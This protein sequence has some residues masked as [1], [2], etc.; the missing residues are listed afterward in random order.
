M[1]YISPSLVA[2]ADSGAADPLSHA[3]IGY[4]TITR[5][6]T[7]TASSAAPGFPASSI[8]HPLTYE[9][10]LPTTAPA[11]LTID[12]GALVLSDYVGI[13]AHTVGSTG[14]VITISYS[15]NGTDWTD[16]LQTGPPND[17]AIM[18]LFEPVLA[19]YWRIQISRVAEIGAVY[20][21]RALVMQRC[22][23]GGHSPGT[24]SR[25]TEIEPSRSVTGQF[26]GRSIVRQGFAT[27]YQ[28]ANLTAPWY[29]ANFDPFVEAALRNP[30]FIAW[31]PEKFPGEV[32]YAWCNHDISPTNQGQR[33]LMSVG[34]NVEAVK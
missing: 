20:I 13:A 16:V 23:Y 31:Y 33:D 28:W 21:G 27:S 14:G 4:S 1:L 15:E 17:N 29:R 6:A 7:V 11:T 24:L 2:M 34:F 32:L 19:R 25:Q 10:W 26:L 22:M 3:R 18:A 30:F 9:R 8:K 12:S 5:N